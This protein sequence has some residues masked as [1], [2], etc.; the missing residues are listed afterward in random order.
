MSGPMHAQWQCPQCGYQASND[1]FTE[2][3]FFR[4]WHVRGPA[5]VKS[6]VESLGAEAYE[7][8]LA[9]Y[10]DKH[11]QLLAVDTV[12]R[13]GVGSVEIPTWKLI[14]RAFELKARGF[15]LVHNHPSG[16]A[17]PSDS[18]VRATSKIARIAD[19]LDLVLF[20]HLIVAGDKLISCGYF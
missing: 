8:L 12:A 10:V 6:Y 13:G 14:N 1:D 20:Q 5:A 16:D 7:W 11:L 9:L 2:N 15:I 18:D 19:D 4:P 17:K 3:V